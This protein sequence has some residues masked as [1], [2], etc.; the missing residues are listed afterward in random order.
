[1]RYCDCKDCRRARRKGKILGTVHR[2]YFSDGGPMRYDAYVPF[3]A[4]FRKGSRRPDAPIV[5]D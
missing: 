3:P 5:M 2:R 4:F 1:M